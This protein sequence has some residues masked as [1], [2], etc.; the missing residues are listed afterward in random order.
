MH[1]GH[2]GDGVL[3]VEYVVVGDVEGPVGPPREG[4]HLVLPP[5]GARGEGRDP[6]IGHIVTETGEVLTPR[7]RVEGVE[8]H[9]AALCSGGIKQ[10]TLCMLQDPIHTFSACS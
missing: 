3:G 9:Q 10:L 8:T 1:V 2:D 4:G 5:R 6:L 7:T